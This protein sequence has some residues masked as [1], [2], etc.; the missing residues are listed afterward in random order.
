MFYKVIPIHDQI[1][2]KY[3]TYLRHWYTVPISAAFSMA[4]YDAMRF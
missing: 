4:S 2:G 3:S 1:A